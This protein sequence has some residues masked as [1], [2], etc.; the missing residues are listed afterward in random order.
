MTRGQ[1]SN[2]GSESNLVDG[3]TASPFPRVS[4][5]PPVSESRPFSRQV[6]WT[7]AVRVLM[8]ANSVL[9]GIIVARWLGAEGVGQLGVI[10]VSVALI[11]QLGSV[12]L[13]SANTYFVARDKERFLAVA[14]NSLVFAIVVGS[15]LALGLTMFASRHPDWFGFIS[16]DLI[17]I[18]AISIP[19]Q[20][21]TLI[22]L[23]IFLAVGNVRRFNLLDL[24]GQSFVLLNA[25]IALVILNKDLWTLVSLNSVASVAIGLLMVILVGAYGARLKTRRQNGGF[26][27]R[28]LGRMLRYGLKFHTSILAGALMF[29]ADLLVVNHFRGPAEAGVYSVAS[30]VAMML[31]LLPGVIATLLFPRVT[32]E[33][34][35]GGETT[36]LVTRHTALVMLLI[37]VA[38]VGLSVIF[39]ALYGPAFSDATVQ[40]L[41]LLPGVYLIGLESVLVQHFNAIGLP[42]AIPLFWLLTL[43]VNLLLVFA[44]V[45]GFGARGA[46]V[47]STVSYLLIFVLVT[48]YFHIKTK[49]SV[50]ETLFLRPDEIRRLLTF[51]SWGSLA[52]GAGR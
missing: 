38:A 42:P 5:S 35:E 23:N 9:A 37:C 8:V 31:M 33:Q 50:S 24:A 40:L 11:V 30:Q 19:F 48:T 20:L 26:D 17:R 1:E 4:P 22:S 12:G 51:K 18:A 25:V 10:N 39:P 46:A 45:P 27:L 44:L 47:A 32:A 41:V 36:A 3:V 28:L 7:L 15:A 2:S 29:R 49:R 43:S 14:L 21:I 13:P 16:P 52:G 6:A 34:D